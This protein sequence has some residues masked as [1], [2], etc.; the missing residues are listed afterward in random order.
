MII[1]RYA[2]VKIAPSNVKYWGQLGYD[3]GRT[4]GKNGMFTGRRLKVK[5][6]E[7][8]AGSN[9]SVSCRCESCG[10]KYVQRLCRD[11]SV[12]HKCRNSN[13]MKGNKFGS[14]NKGRPSILA[15]ENHPRWNPNKPKLS[16]DS[17]IS[18]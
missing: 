16:L 13:R 5:V 6:H 9:V 3:V 1:S 17:T 7:L 12:C 14:A 18:R 10:E 15:G 11:T 4:G 8:K 2:Y